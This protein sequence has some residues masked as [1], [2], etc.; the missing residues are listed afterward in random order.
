M[1]VSLLQRNTTVSLRNLGSRRPSSFTSVNHGIV[2]VMLPHRLN[3]TW[4]GM[5]LGGFFKRGDERGTT[6]RAV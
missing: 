4:I 3:N 6:A 2:L 5:Y 1:G